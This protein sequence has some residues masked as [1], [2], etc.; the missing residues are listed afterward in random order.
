[1]SGNQDSAR[2]FPLYVIVHGGGET[3]APDN[4]Q[5][6]D[7][8]REWHLQF[9]VGTLFKFERTELAGPEVGSVTAAIDPDDLTP[10]E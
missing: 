5:T 8:A 2:S 4:I 10:G 9:G 3:R 6:D 7:A 1:M